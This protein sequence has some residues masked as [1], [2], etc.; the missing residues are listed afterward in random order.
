MGLFSK[1]PFKG[2]YYRAD[3]FATKNKNRSF[4]D[5]PDFA[6]AYEWSANFSHEGRQSSWRGHDLRWKAHICVWAASH[7]LKIEGDFVE[8][9]VA[10]ALSSGTILKCLG[11]ENIERKFWLF[12][13]FFGT[14]LVEGMNQDELRAREILNAR[15]Y[16]DCY[17]YVRA[18]TVDYPNVE[19]VRGVLPGT[20][21]AISERR[22]A[23][24]AVDLNNA[25]SEA[26]VI[27]RLWPQLSTGAIVVIDDYGF[28]GHEAQQNIWD[29]FAKERGLMVGSL[30]TGQGLLIKA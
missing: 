24:L 29:T 17:E 1:A 23:Y 5:R 22:I 12:D 15:H 30:P 13:T 25:P 6:A 27:E 14:P 19:L 26:G 4:M 7:A 11:L 9:G 10:I 21:D 16:F 28:I 18:K 8:C 2:E 3:G 20:L